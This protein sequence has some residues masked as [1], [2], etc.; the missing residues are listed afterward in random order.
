MLLGILGIPLPLLPTV[1]FLLLAAYCFAK[2]S[3]RLHTW[4]I[5]HPKFGPP[6]VAWREHGAISRRAKYMATAMMTGA[7]YLSIYLGFDLS[8]VLL[9]ITA[10]IAVGA[11]IWSRPEGGAR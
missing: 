1:P 9:Q 4:L 2:S 5:T 3:E 7:L 11:F 10:L 6:I 8:I